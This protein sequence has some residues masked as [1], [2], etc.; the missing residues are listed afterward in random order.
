MKGAVS[1][2]KVFQLAKT[3]R[4]ELLEGTTEHNIL[5]DDGSLISPQGKTLIYFKKAN[6]IN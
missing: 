4:R 2:Q 3:E 1:A 5:P 6:K